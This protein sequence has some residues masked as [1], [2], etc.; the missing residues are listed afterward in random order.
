MNTPHW[1]KDAIF[2]H[3]YPLGL[4]GAPAENSFA[5]PSEYRLEGL[6]SW[7][8]HLQWL[9]VNAIY[10]GPVFQ[11]NQHGYD[12][13]DLFH[14]DRRLG[15]NQTMKYLS[16]EIHRR[17]MRLVLDG[18]F[19]HV[20][21]SFWAFRDLQIR[22]Q[23]SAYKDWFSGIRFDQ[24]NPYGEPFTYDTWDGHY[25]LPK[26]NLNHP[27]VC[28][29][30]L[31]AVQ[32]WIKDW[33][34]DGLRLDAADNVLP[35]FWQALHTS[36]KQQKSDFWLMGEVVHGDYRNWINPE[37]LDSAT[38]YEAYKGLYSSLNDANYYEIAY[39]LN[40]QFGEGGI[41]QDRYLYNFVDNHDVNRIASQ[42]NNQEHLVPLY[43]ML[44]GM[45]GIPSIYYGSEWGVQGLRSD[46]SDRELRPYLDLNEMIQHA[47][48]AYLPATIR[49]LIAIRKDYP[50]LRYGNYRQLHVNHQTIAFTRQFKNEV[51]LIAI[52]A[53]DTTVTLENLQ[54]PDVSKIRQIYPYQ[55]K[56][57]TDANS[58]RIK[59]LP[60][61]A[62]YFTV[63]RAN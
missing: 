52:N 29:H 19:N 62:S 40:R 30:L 15:D 2:Y 45:P 41:Y 26:L 49:D 43:A 28:N 56:E 38:N 1:V 4:L 8:D 7:L 23:H 13:A 25:S 47:P 5:L 54:L 58:E 21:R 60:Y 17:G 57:E 35:E 10:L 33:D 9:G 48:I 34:I 46:Y 44:F 12:T 16:Q 63:E 6:Y 20:G 55:A 51:V 27:A 37:M 3:I 53:G 24:Q 31:D 18:V 61:Q 22:G 14:I 39:T 42:L 50:A 11:S 36:T 32:M 59:V